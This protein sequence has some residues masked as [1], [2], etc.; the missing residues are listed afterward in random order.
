[1]SLDK[2]TLRKV[3]TLAAIRMSDEE[4]TRTQE[5]LNN[6]MGMI[7]Q[8]GDVDTDNVAPLPSPVNIALK[9]RPDDLTDGG[10]AAAVLAN[11]PE[12]MEGFYVVPKVVE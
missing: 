12:E 10:C 8:L 6:I 1:M 9:L 5:K 3:A 4:L 11:A 2:A 7:A